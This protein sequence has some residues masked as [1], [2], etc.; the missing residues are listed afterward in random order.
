[1]RPQSR[2]LRKTL[3]SNRLTKKTYEVL[4]E[5][6][7]VDKA[8]RYKVRV[9]TKDNKIVFEDEVKGTSAKAR[10]PVAQELTGN[11]TAESNEGIDADTSL[12]VSL[13]VQGPK[14]NTPNIGKIAE[15]DTRVLKWD[16]VDYAE[17]YEMVLEIKKP[18]GT[19]HEIYKKTTP[20]LQI[21]YSSPL[22]SGTYRINV[23]A[24]AKL[25]DDSDFA[26]KVFDTESSKDEELRRASYQL[27]DANFLRL[28]L[29]PTSFQYSNNSLSFNTTTSFP[30]V[31]ATGYLS[32]GTWF[33]PKSKWGLILTG[34]TEG[35]PIL[36]STATYQVITLMG[37]RKFNIGKSS[38]FRFS[39]GAYEMTIPDI[40]SDINGNYYTRFDDTLGPSFRLSYL[41]GF[42][43][44]WGMEASGQVFIDVTGSAPGGMDVKTQPTFQG[45]L[46]VTRRLSDHLRA[47]ADL[48]YRSQNIGYNSNSNF[49]Q[50]SN[51]NNGSMNT[52]NMTSESLIFSV[53]WGF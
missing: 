25:R 34:E 37:V 39:F 11:V 31:G 5:W 44:N 38:Q 40:V 23:K 20:R 21:V 33:K 26:S 18:D 22:A 47:M 24:T 9:E 36:G 7:P 48:L 2:T 46:G 30:A 51:Q 14:L 1:L 8:D 52:T 27:K 16:G 41:I 10:V 43:P 35:F 6:L 3:I 28:G 13:A 42:T 19:F 15:L 29:G 50:G 45:S 4:F 53:E 49:S 12:P 17:T 32:A